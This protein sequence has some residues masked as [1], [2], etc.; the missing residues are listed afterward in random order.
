VVLVALVLGGYGVARIADKQGLWV[1]TVE[2]TAGFPEAHDITPGTPVRVRGVDAGQVVAVEY[3]DHDGPGAQVTVRMRLQA[4]F[5]SR[6]YADAS[7]QIHGSGL[8]GSKVIAIQPGD[9]RKGAPA[10][11]RVRGVKPFDMDE[12]VAEVRDLAKE[13]KGSAAEVKALAKDARETV[14]SA[15]GVIDSVNNGNGTLSKLLRDDDLYQDARRLI[16]R[17][18]KTVGAVEGE[19]ANLKGLVSD[20]RDTLRSVKQG[21]D[22]LGKMPLVRSYVEDAAAI[23]VRPHMTRER[24]VYQAADLFEPGTAVLTLPGQIHLNNLSGGLK[25]NQT[26]GSEVV[27]AAFFDAE[28]KSQTSASALELTKKQAEAVVNHLRGAGVHKMGWVTRRKMTPLGMGTALSPVAEPH[29]LPP[30][31]VEV[32][33][34][35]PR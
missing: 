12:A 5:A 27:A 14:A 28:D 1:D 35:T 23:L 11:G 32:V 10:D 30:T 25:A 24:W 33:M 26:S 34:F 18:D 13:A 16:A 7:A 22:A 2:I 29:P 20:G 6:I 3:P 17:T 4:R 21:T 9:P 15:K 19:M 31:R 8:L